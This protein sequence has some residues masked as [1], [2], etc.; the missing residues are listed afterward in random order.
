MLLGELLV[1]MHGMKQEDIDR[2]L[3]FQEQYGG[4]LGS[5][6]V[7]MGILAE[8]AL[9]EALSCQLSLKCLCE[10][11]LAVCDWQAVETEMPVDPEFFIARKSFPLGKRDDRWF[12]AAVDPLNL[13][14]NTCLAEC[15]MDP[16]F[17]ICTETQFRELSVTL[18]QQTTKGGYLEGL[19]D[20]ID[21]IEK[22]RELA[23][24]APIVNLLNS[25]IGRAIARGASD[26]HFEPY[27][28][29][30]RVRFRIDGLLHDVDFLPRDM[31]LAVVSRIKILA[32]LDIAEKRKPQDGKIAMRVASQELDIR[33]STLPLG[34]GESVVLRFLLKESIRYDLD[35]LGLEEDLLTQ[36]NSDICKTSGVILLTGPTGSGK[37]TTLY[38]ALN[39]INRE[40]RKI[41]TVEDPIEYQLE[42]INQVQVN[43]EIGY[44]FPSALRSIVRQ[45]PDVIMIGEIR[46]RDT[47]KI[48]MQASLTGHLVFSTLHTN[49]APSACTRLL[50]LGVEEYLLNSA[51]VSIIAQRLVRKLCPHCKEKVDDVEVVVRSQ[52]ME[53]LLNRTGVSK[54]TIF[55]P[56]GCGLCDKSGYKG[57][58]GIMEYMS[59]DRALKVMEKDA[60]FVHSAREYLSKKGVRNLVEDGMLKVFKGIT[61]VEE[62][63]RVAG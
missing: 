6:L 14:V 38:S 46:D 42:G 7:N 28:S 20:L 1:K 23:T 41:I 8:D 51:L 25:F 60:H 48:A 57:R 53:H 40:D 49:D 32:A 3:K 55:R 26:L 50:D 11:D 2:A 10:D 59:H 27:K 62:V 4:K 63:L 9:V 16:C 18:R 43:P 37:T 52:S 36:L 47:S 5:I 34:Q 31:E 15:G 35:V 22:L 54:P 58:V 12:F 33:V 30:Y 21:D 44:D 24:E 19:S 17:L 56:V 29:M 39:R 61:S 45:D 13:E